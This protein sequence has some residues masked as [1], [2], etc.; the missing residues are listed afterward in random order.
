MQ[1]V[2]I[3]A[4]IFAVFKD[5]FSGLFKNRQVQ[6][7]LIGVG[8]YYLYTTTKKKEEKEKILANLPSN[9][10]GLLAQRLHAAFH[11]YISA[12][13]FGV[14]LPDGTDEAA[15]QSIAVEM[16]KKKNYEAVAE[17]FNLLFS[18]KLDDE[19]RSEGVFDDFFNTY[20]AQAGGSGGGTTTN[21]PINTT[22]V[23]NFKKGDIVF[24]KGGY[25]L[26]STSAPYGVVDSTVNGEDWILYNNPYMSTIGGKQGYWV[27][28]EQP[29][30]RYNFWPS[31]YVVFLDA[32]YKK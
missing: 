14:Y 9:E 17:A 29:K 1:Y 16:G 8:A 22:T 3:I 19:L 2:A 27:V 30:S 7:L 31:Y 11:P 15:V 4:A 26:R 13:I 23:K 5:N 32:L 21:P 18:Q 10:A 28:I 20:N 6:F 24:S 25:N 12:P